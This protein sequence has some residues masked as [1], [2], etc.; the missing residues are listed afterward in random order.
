M[1]R[2]KKCRRVGQLPL[3]TFYNP[4]GAPLEG[5]NGLS[6]PVDGLEAMRLADAEAID[7]AKASEIMGVSR[8]TFSRILNEARQ[9][10]AKALSNGWAIHIDGGNFNISEELPDIGHD[11]CRRRRKHGCGGW[12]GIQAGHDQSLQENIK[13]PE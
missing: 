12:N 6:L 11:D 3:H 5:L 10:V 13:N 9:I 2:P 1:P 7:H 4:R 8:P